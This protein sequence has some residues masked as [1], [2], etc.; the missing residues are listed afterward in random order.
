MGWRDPWENVDRANA[1]RM[2]SDAQGI[3]MLS[4]LQGAQ[5][6]ALQQQSMTTKMAEEARLRDRQQRIEQAL[7]G[8]GG[9]MEKA[10]PAITQ[11]APL[12]AFKM[13]KDAEAAALEADSKRASTAKA[14][15]DALKSVHDISKQS[16]GAVMQNPTPEAALAAI[17]QIQGTLKTLNLPGDLSSEIQQVQSFK[18][19]EEIKQWAAGRA[20]AADKLLPTFQTRNTGGATDTLA[21]NPVTGKVDIANSVR[22]TVS[23]DAQLSAETARRGQNMTDARAREALNAPQY[24]ET[25]AGLVALPKRLAN[26]QAPTATPVLGGDGQPLGKPLKA[27]PPAVN[28]AIIGNAQSLYSLDKA[29]SLLGGK[30]VD[31]AKGDKNATGWKGYLPQAILNRVDPTGVDAR[32]EVSDIGSLKIHDRSGAA[33][34]ISES[35]RLMPFIPQATDDPAVAIRKLTRLKEEAKRMQDGLAE[36]YSKDQGYRT[37]P[38]LNR[39]GATGGWKDL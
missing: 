1:L 32:A 11:F 12:D 4:A 22:N 5:T 33:V 17:N 8:A 3:N 37:N 34:T 16:F 28:D 19:P 2:Q 10:I 25:D 24:M 39:A 35:P 27:L 29:I 20:M 7:I 36:T 30:N 31:S 18:T 15:A 6:N 9:D 26:G 38:I 13:K 21:I 14:R 23:P